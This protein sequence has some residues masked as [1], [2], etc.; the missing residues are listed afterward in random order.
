MRLPAFAFLFAVAA[1]PVVSQ[2]RRV[3]APPRQRLEQP[4]EGIPISH[5]D[6]DRLTPARVILE[7]REALKLQKAQIAK[8]DSIGRAFGDSAKKLADSVKK[9]QRAVT[10][11]PPM[12]KRPP[13]GKPETKKD[14][15]KRAQL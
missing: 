14:S 11:A 8:L 5:G 15:L 7:R 6:I 2:P 13:E 12:L 1:H 4:S 3:M 9:Y 10:T